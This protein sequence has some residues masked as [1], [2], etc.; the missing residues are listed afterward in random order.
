[1]ASSSG[2]GVVWSL[3]QDVRELL[4]RG[5]GL[6]HSYKTLVHYEITAVFL[7]SIISKSIFAPNPGSVNA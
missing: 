2:R 6:L 4:W 5:G 1:M 7:R 3:E